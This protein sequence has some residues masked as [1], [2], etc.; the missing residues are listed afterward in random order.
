MNIRN[1]D[2]AKLLMEHVRIGLRY[3]YNSPV[4]KSFVS[5]RNIERG[6]SFRF[7]EEDEV[8]KVAESKLPKLKGIVNN[9]GGESTNNRKIMRKEI[10]RRRRSFDNQVWQ[11]ISNLR[12]A[13]SNPTR[14]KAL[15]HI[16][17]GF[18]PP[19]NKDGESAK[20]RKLRTRR[21]TLT[22]DD[23]E[24]MS[25]HQLARRYGNM[26]LEFD[27][28]QKEMLLLQ[29]E[30][31]DYYRDVIQ[32]EDSCI[33]FLNVQTDELV[34]FHNG[35]W[36]RHAANV[37]FAGDCV[38]NG[39]VVHVTNP[40]EDIRYNKNIDDAFGVTTRN[41]L[42][43]PIRANRGGG[44]IIG[45][46]TMTN[47]LGGDFESTDLD[48]MADCVRRISDELHIRFRELLQA[49]DLLAGNSKYISDSSSKTGNTRKYDDPTAAS[50]ASQYKGSAAES[51]DPA[52]VLQPRFSGPNAISTREKIDG[53]DKENRRRAYS[54]GESDDVK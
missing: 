3:E 34:M 40:T 14:E 42:C 33:Q 5:T 15:E 19:V 29:K 50:R 39:N 16:R 2:H 47:K 8:A 13:T 23:T 25:S 12:T 18:F 46:L 11:S 41:I 48:I 53:R 27:M 6:I 31:L 28:I 36:Y 10:N 22:G 4:R 32:C 9:D 7:D 35:K 38:V 26:A 49:A 21:W 17:E 54:Q 1:F 43:H 20:E 24:G 45:V 30:Q 51:F 37:G 44:K 52:L